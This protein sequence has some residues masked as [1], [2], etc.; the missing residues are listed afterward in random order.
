MID[1]ALKKRFFLLDTG[2]KKQ[3]K[4]FFL[5]RFIPIR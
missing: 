2:A 1:K 4:R 5:Y 3:G